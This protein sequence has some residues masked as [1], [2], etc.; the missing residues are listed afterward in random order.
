[1]AIFLL[2]YNAGT[3]FAYE[4][5]IS[6]NGQETANTESINQ[7]SQTSVSQTNN[8]DITNRIEAV[9]ETGGNTISDTNGNASSIKTGN[10][11]QQT[12]VQ[13]TVNSS[14]IANECCPNSDSSAEI[15][16]NGSNSTNTESINANSQ[17][18]ITVN[19][20]AAITNTI[21]GTANTGKNRVSDTLG[22]VTIKTGDIQSNI[23]LVNSP[24][25][26]TKIYGSAR[27]LASTL[28]IQGNGSNTYT[29]ITSKV[30]NPLFI[31]SNNNATITNSVSI[32][33][34][35]GDNYVYDTNGIVEILTGDIFSK[36]SL[37]NNVNTTLIAMPCLCIPEVKA[38]EKPNFPPV[39]QNQYPN[40]SQGGG[41]ITENA[42][43]TEAP[44]SG[45]TIFGLSN[46]SGD[47]SWDVNPTII[48][49][50]FMLSG[51]AFFISGLNHVSS[52]SDRTLGNLP[53]V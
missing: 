3:T 45:P 42:A 52:T 22:N 20:N 37:K 38:V 18:T 32:D 47:V 4:V 14:Q 28:V 27:L 50:F 13:N 16:N 31:V 40:P 6:S 41:Q 7:S 5:V 30:F 12:V 21:T 8:S 43:S 9:S 10:A 1:M 2:S 19:Q 23:S 26:T 35:S 15:S 17:T 33:L 49:L 36:I 34:K 46:T 39:P 29:T 53:S 48:A 51:M 24:I 11:I 25:N 44:S